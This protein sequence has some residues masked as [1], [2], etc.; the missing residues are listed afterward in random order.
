MFL[1]QSQSRTSPVRRVSARRCVMAFG[2]AVVATVCP[3]TVS[4]QAPVGATERGQASASASSLDQIL[5]QLSTYDGGIESDAAWKLR[6]YVYARKDEAVG[7]AEC[8]GKLLPFLRSPAT[9][10][11]KMIAARYLRVIASDSAVLALQA[12]L[13][14]ERLADLAIYTLQQIPGGAAEAALIQTT[15]TAAGAT[16]IALVSA[17]GER[18]AVAA[19]PAIVPLLQQPATAAIAATALGRIGGTEAVAALTVAYASAPAAL[20]PVVASSLLACAETALAAKDNATA[21]RLYE[22]LTSDAAL[23]INIRKAAV[24]GRLSASGDRVA[25]MRYFT[26]PGTSMNSS[27]PQGVATR[28]AVGSDPALRA[29]AIAKIA[30]LF[31]PEE[32]APICALLSRLTDSEKIQLLAVL[33]AY[34]GERVAPAV[35]ME[36]TSPTVEVRLAALKALGAAAGPS[37]VL[38]LAEVAAMRRGPEQAAAR[39]ALGSLRGRA[40][41]D[42]VIAQLARKPP[43]GIAGELLLSVGDRRIFP[44][45]AVVAAALTSPSPLI[46]IQALKALRGIGT[47]S[48]MAAVLDRLPAIEDETELAE[49]EKTVAAL[50]LTIENPDGR[51]RTVKARLASEKLPRSRMQLIGLLPLIGD[52]S[53][54]PALRGLLADEDAGVFDA[55]VR[56]IAAWP[57]PAAREDLLRLARDSRVET[58]RLLAI[59]GL[60]RIVGLDKYR[61]QQS[62]VADLRQAAGFSWRPEEQKLVLGALAQFPCREALELADGFLREPAVK[63]EAKAAIDRITA[64][65]AREAIR[66]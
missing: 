56:A 15:K 63:A 3:G 19:V 29:A 39:S 47:P 24:A 23:P 58:H 28:V 46:R 38:P 30:D 18:R 41:D 20:R 12:M 36:L 61:D 45:K 65:L 33:S 31:P 59:G 53:A 51:S 54:L 64:R 42:E 52:N 10:A 34:P 5:E 4:A 62:S 50:A 40:V 17:L 48:D 37:A 44:A 6:D 1:H 57:T 43:D 66:K 7:R 26:E 60:V 55:A 8:E 32:I 2:I 22:T 16:K 14:D 49:V 9:P 13:V 27:T 11:A 21:L 35:M 25:L